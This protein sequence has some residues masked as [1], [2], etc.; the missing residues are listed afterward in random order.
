M[1]ASLLFVISAAVFLR[2]KT[3]PAFLQL[4]DAGCLVVVVFTHI[5][6]ALH[7]LRWM[8]NRTLTISSILTT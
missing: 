6:E 8:T 3:Q 7:V 1:P 5:A 4:V 2:R